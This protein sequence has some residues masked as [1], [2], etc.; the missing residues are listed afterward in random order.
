MRKSCLQ[1]PSHFGKAGNL[2]FNDSGLVV[3]MW[4]V[5]PQTGDT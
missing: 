1:L 5:L 2:F 4:T 3:Y